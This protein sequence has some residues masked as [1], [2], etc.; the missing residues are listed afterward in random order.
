MAKVKPKGTKTKAETKTG[1]GAIT[2]DLEKSY[3]RGISDMAEEIRTVLNEKLGPDGWTDRSFEGYEKLPG[4][5]Q[6]VV[7]TIGQIV[8][9]PKA[10]GGKPTEQGWNWKAVKFPKG[11]ATALRK[12]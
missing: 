5:N 9:W 10:L 6:E 12:K 8:G 2:L 11:S 4:V 7:T 3:F 1:K